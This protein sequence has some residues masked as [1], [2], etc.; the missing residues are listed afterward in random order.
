M[1]YTVK[2]INGEHNAHQTVIADTVARGD[3]FA[4]INPDFIRTV[5]AQIA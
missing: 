3:S 1:F 2:I 5:S 4:G